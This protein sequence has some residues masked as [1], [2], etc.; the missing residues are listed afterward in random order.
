MTTSVNCYNWSEDHLEGFLKS[1]VMKGNDFD[2]IYQTAKTMFDHISKHR[3]ESWTHDMNTM[4][5]RL[6]VC[7]NW[8]PLYINKRYLQLQTVI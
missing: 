4:A 8:V 7:I 2:V 6:G 1:F 5:C 3:Q